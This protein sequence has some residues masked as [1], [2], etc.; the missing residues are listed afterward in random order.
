MNQ[1]LLLQCYSV[2]WT[3]HTTELFNRDPLQLLECGHID[4]LI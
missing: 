1:R 4:L 3:E 2:G